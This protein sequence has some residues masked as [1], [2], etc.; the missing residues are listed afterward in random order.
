M[1]VAGGTGLSAT[2]MVDSVAA[3][4]DEANNELVELSG[5]RKNRR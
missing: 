5:K 4:P 2:T 1:A 3:S